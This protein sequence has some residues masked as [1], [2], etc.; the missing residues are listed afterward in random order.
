MSR[1]ALYLLGPPRI[2]LDREPV[3]VG[4]RKAVALL[5]YLAVEGDRHSR[6]ALAALL[7]P[8]FGQGG[9]RAE[10][11]R[12][13][14]VLNRTL[15]EGWL[16]ADRETVGLSPDPSTSSGQALCLDIDR[17]RQHLSACEAHC[18]PSTQGCP[19]CL[20]RLEAAVGLYRGD[21]MDGFSLPDSLDF[22]EWQR[23]QTESLRDELA[24]ALERL[25]GLTAAKGEYE[26]AIGHARRWLAMDPTHEPAHRALMRLYV[27]A[28]RRGAALRQYRHCVR[29]LEAELGVVP[30]PE[31]TALYEA[32][33]KGSPRPAAAKPVSLPPPSFAMHLPAFLT[34]D[35]PPVAV[36]APVFV[37]R[38]RE[39]AQLER[40]LKAAIDG[41]G[42]VVFVTGGP[43]RGKTALMREFA[44]RALA[45]RPDLLVASGGCNAYSGVGDPYLPFREMM[46]TLTA[47]VEARW[48]AGGVSTGHARRLWAALPT[49]AQLLLDRGPHLIDALASG[50]ALLER[51]TAAAH[52]LDVTGATGR[53]DW[54]TQLRSWVGREKGE[55]SSLEQSALFQ[56][57][58]NVLCALSETHPLLLMLDD[59]QW[60]DAGS[61]GLLF[62]LGRRLA[63]AGARVLIMG[64]YRPEEL[65]LRPEAVEGRQDRHPLLKALTEF[66]RQWGDAWIDLSEADDA[67]SRRFVEALLDSEPNRLGASFREALAQRT[68][69]HPLFAVELLRA[70]QQRCDLVQD[71]DGR[72]SEGSVLDWE[73]LPARVEAVIRARVD[74]L[75]EELHDLLTVASV[76]GER[77]TAQMVAQVQGLP[78][79]QVL[80][81]LSQRLGPRGHRLVHEAEEVQVDGRFLFRYR[82]SHALFQS[83]LYESMSAGEQRLLHG[84]V[85]TALEALYGD[86]VEQ[87]VVQ[88][89][90]HFDAAGQWD[91]AIEYALRAG[92]QARLAY[93]NAEAIGYY[94]RA[95]DLLRASPLEG[96]A[97]RKDWRLTAL[98][99]LG[100][101]HQGA[102]QVV[103]AEKHLRE[104]ISV[105]KEMGSAPHDLVR[106][107]WWL[108]EA[109]FW[110][111]RYDEFGRNAEEGLALLGDDVESVEGALMLGHLGANPL[112]DWD[113]GTECGDRLAAFLRRLPYGPELRPAFN[114]VFARSMQNRDGE[115]AL[116]WIRSLEERARRHYDLLALS[117]VHLLAGWNAVGSGDW[118]SG[119]M[120]F[121]QGLE[122][123]ARIGDSKQE[124]WCSP[125][126][127][128]RL[129]SMGELQEAE[130]YALRGLKTAQAAGKNKDNTAMAHWLMGR[131]YLC[132]ADWNKAI[133]ACET[134]VQLWR[135]IRFRLAEAWA[136]A[137]L[138]RVYLTQGKRTEALRHF[139]Q[140][141]TLAG[142]EDSTRSEGVFQEDAKRDRAYAPDLALSG[143]E[144]AF[145]DPEAFHAFCRRF[146]EERPEIDELPFV[147]WFLEPAEPTPL[148][149]GPPLCDDA[150]VSHLASDWMW[151]DPFDDCSFCVA[152]L[153]SIPEHQRSGRSAS[154][155]G[156][157]Q[158]GLEIHAANGRDLWYIN[159]S[160]PRLLRRA[161]EG[162]DFA[163]QTVCGP[164]STDRPAIGGLLLW[165]DKKNYLQLERGMRGTHEISFEG[166][167][168]NADVIIGRGRLAVGESANR[169]MGKPANRIFLRLER[170]GHRVSAL[171]SADGDQWF[172]VGD[173]EFSIEG[174]VQ[175]GLHAIGI[176]DRTIFHGAYPDGTAIRFESFTI[177]GLEH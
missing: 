6:D 77:F 175:V 127:G 165:K 126:L 41:R 138:G 91:K 12:A 76:E 153:R 145:E 102:G 38:E 177:W 57:F 134:A 28:G 133:D 160:A 103:E 27:E 140:A 176:V 174:P 70:M 93:A 105:G 115:E 173:V 116:K 147:Q 120:R 159:R 4:R 90:H 62:H 42:Q 36:E 59:L 155:A 171:C 45:A 136:T 118:H 73:T 15:G 162:E 169:R 113:R 37:A 39:L 79:R 142:P 92:D 111:S 52:P 167:L 78:E 1:L 11:R 55:H 156:T 30:S 47:D 148:G 21:F 19:D 157:V 96:E 63:D 25:A 20:A 71:A 114:V 141:I 31:T 10:L 150:F 3:H 172:T 135:D 43:G 75:G 87:I 83:Y 56:Q 48:A 106:L 154:E 100:Q 109:L 53:P 23:F 54:L 8:E 89:A 58:T 122:L 108:G 151:E 117:E 124:C 7:W 64:A 161:P 137:A 129:L 88:L 32:L 121:R 46:G 146:R 123:S 5:A 128:N 149:D 107:H 164:A 81:T 49:M 84:E 29:V 67:A 22:D 9:A 99:G 143:L 131:I 94:Q 132:Q 80:K 144:E 130:A 40:Y 104:A 35:E 112:G 85:G 50:P 101:A 14:S 158:Y 44:R 74:P 98:R 95:L 86:Q 163:V 82:F 152:S 119:I 17:F 16:A 97:V 139:R 18:H 72:W 69:G 66:Q 170:V 51:A 125:N 168:E 110:Q 68:G 34:Q 65:A 166:C 26:E 61:A 24:S 33:R 2:E 13:L 60:V